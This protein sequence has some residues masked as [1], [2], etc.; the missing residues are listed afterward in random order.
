MSKA[1]YFDTDLYE[2]DTAKLVVEGTPYLYQYYSEETGK[3]FRKDL[4]I[5]GWYTTGDD[6]N[7]T[8]IRFGKE[9]PITIDELFSMKSTQGAKVRLSIVGKLKRKKRYSVCSG[10]FKGYVW[11]LAGYR[12]FE[13]EP[14]DLTKV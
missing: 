6:S 4:E 3:P 1:K 14:A 2:G 12:L 8:L 13:D 5:E 9:K 10:E 7:L 11:D